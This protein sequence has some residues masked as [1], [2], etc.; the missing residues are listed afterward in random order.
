MRH[1]PIN[2]LIWKMANQILCWMLR[3]G[4][5]KVSKSL[6]KDENGPMS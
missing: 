3:Y 4:Q 5:L 2:L 1:G 6:K